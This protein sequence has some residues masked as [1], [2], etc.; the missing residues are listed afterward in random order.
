M[1]KLPL[2]IMI[3]KMLFHVIG[4]NLQ[5][6]NVWNLCCLTQE[7][8]PEVTT[9]PQ[10]NTLINWSRSN[11][12]PLSRIGKSKPVFCYTNKAICSDTMY[13]LNNCFCLGDSLQCGTLQM[14]INNTMNWWVVTISFTAMTAYWSLSF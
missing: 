3:Q 11:H 13:L 14:V 8:W 5:L 1:W 7:C 12:S 4:C 2:F 9:L 10:M 6:T